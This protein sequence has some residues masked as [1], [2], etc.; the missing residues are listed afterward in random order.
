MKNNYL[1]LFLAAGIF[2]LPGCNDEEA[3]APL[4]DINVSRYEFPQGNNSWD[5]DI[6][7]I[8]REY[9]VYCIYEGFTSKDLDRQWTNVGSVSTYSGTAVPYE[10]V[11][12]YVNFNKEYV[13]PC[14]GK[15][16]HFPLY[17][18]FIK[19][20]RYAGTSGD[21]DRISSKFDG[22]DYWAISFTEEDMADGSRDEMIRVSNGVIYALLNNYFQRGKLTEPDHFRDGI[23]YTTAVWDGFASDKPGLYQRG[24]VDR[25]KA[26]F[27]NGYQAWNLKL[28]TTDNGDFWGY[29]RSAMFHPEAVFR[30]KYPADT[31]PLL[32]KR[33]DMVVA[34]VLK[35][36]GIDL[37]K[38]AQRKLETE[39]E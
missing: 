34:Q 33:Y 6:E 22:F 25:V 21:E 5:K 12:F 36:T 31:Y 29:V 20:F 15:E 2:L 19:D 38:V 16:V 18:Y 39:E 4:E 3:L 26:S 28:L 17:Y 23:D 13:F 9:G 35:Q 1:F 30:E 8:W 7:E 14:I 27:A 24:F 37:K 11:P 10:E 32:Q